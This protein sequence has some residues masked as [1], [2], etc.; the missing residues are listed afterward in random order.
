MIT[1]KDI[2]VFG[3]R[4]T[5]FFH[6]DLNLLSDTLDNMI[7]ASSLYGYHVHYALKANSNRELLQVISEKGLGADC[8]SG[9]EIDR[10]IETGFD[11]RSIAFAGVGKTDVEIKTGLENDIFTFNVESL[12]ELEVI[13]E[14]AGNMAKKAPIA[15][16]INPN[17]NARTHQYITT[18]LEENKFGIN[19]W[20]FETVLERLEKLDHL[21]LKGLHFHIGSQITD[22]SVF[23]G[24]CIRINEI[25]EWFIEHRIIA[26]H[27]NVGGGLGI[28]YEHPDDKLI[29]DFDQFFKVFNDHL[30]LQ[31]NQELHFELGRS[32]VA[33]CGNLITKVLYIKNGVNVDFAIVDAGMTE[34]IRPALYQSTH[35]IEKI[36]SDKDSLEKK[37]D[38]VG[39]ICESSD[40]FAKSI[41]LPELKRGDTVAIRSV[42]AYG[43][44][45]SSGYNL[46]TKVK[47]YYSQV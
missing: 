19:S 31:P 36:E 27:I 12:Q 1:L 37:Y 5:P 47:S 23:K 40:C 17:V 14:L 38:V 22:M 42:G 7:K 32:I 10:A 20:E 25:Q 16:R 30:E 4:E 28:N 44:V 9:N 21:E 45:M 15:L 18:G 13:N 34:L 2:S 33:Q 3:D 8:V 43:E 39:P 41:I 24:L 35:K 6:Y 11:K 46:R 29:P 26:E